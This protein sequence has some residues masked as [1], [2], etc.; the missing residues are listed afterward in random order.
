MSSRRCR[1]TT[2]AVITL[3]LARLIEVRWLLHLQP[4]R[5]TF[6]KPVVAGLLGGLATWLVHLAL[7]PLPSWGAVIA[8][9]GT[10]AAV[11]P[12]ALYFMGFDAEDLVVLDR[13]RSRFSGASR[14]TP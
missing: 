9:V 6:L 8:G 2:A 13:I 3:N 10:L 7:P 14:G 11:Y 4:Y 5:I 12:A 1:L